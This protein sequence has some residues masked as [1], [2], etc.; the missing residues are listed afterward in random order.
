[1]YVSTYWC[2]LFVLFILYSA[3]LYHTQRKYFF[4]ILSLHLVVYPQKVVLVYNKKWG[5]SPVSF[6]VSLNRKCARRTVWWAS[7]S[8][9][10]FCSVQ[11]CLR[12][13]KTKRKR[14]WQ[15]SRNA[16]KKEIPGKLKPQ[17]GKERRNDGKA[18]EGISGKAGTTGLIPAPT[19]WCNHALISTKGQTLWYSRYS[20]IPLRLLIK[21]LLIIR[22]F[23]A[24]TEK[25]WRVDDCKI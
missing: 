16:E 3:Y 9:F 14:N 7:P 1:M 2:E 11:N 6:C 25:C 24:D 12:T 22:L 23:W 21:K 19:Y 10:F 20:V 15:E 17:A 13:A 8:Y 4:I 18:E 5:G